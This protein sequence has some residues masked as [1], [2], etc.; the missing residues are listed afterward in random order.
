MIWG[1]LALRFVQYRN[2][3]FSCFFSEAEPLELILYHQHQ[4]EASLDALDVKGVRVHQSVG[5]WEVH[6]TGG[7]AAGARAAAGTRAGAAPTRCSPW[8]RTA[9]TW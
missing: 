8:H 5:G 7:A 2:L 9:R 3:V 1:A 6:P 4:I